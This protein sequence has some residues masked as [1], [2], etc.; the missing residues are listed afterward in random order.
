MTMLILSLLHIVAG[1][2][3]AGAALFAFAFLEPVVEALGPAGGAFMQKL[4]TGTK[5]MLVMPLVGVLTILSGAVM[6]W[7]VSDHF[8]PA[9]LTSA[10]GIVIS[11][12][13]FAGI[14]AAM[15]GGMGKRLRARLLEIRAGLKGAAPDAA[16]QA[17]MQTLTAAL[18]TRS[19][20]AAL[21]IL[22]ALCCMAAAH[23]L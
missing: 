14:L 18:R 20:A 9:W 15:A 11:I 6:Y 12:G 2:F 17:E 23:A 21:L 22:L 8:A 19:R 7:M 16:Q 3:W 10:H 4:M 5:L 13:A 1:A